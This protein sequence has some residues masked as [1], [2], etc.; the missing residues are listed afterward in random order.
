[1]VYGFLAIAAAAL[2][3]TT[4]ASIVPTQTSSTSNVTQSEPELSA[5]QVNV[6]ELLSISPEYEYVLL[7]SAYDGQAEGCVCLKGTGTIQGYKYNVSSGEFEL[8][9]TRELVGHTQ[10]FE[11]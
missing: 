5:P 8:K 2:V 9:G 10:C 4:A 7:S 3:I 6:K 1:M 11:Y